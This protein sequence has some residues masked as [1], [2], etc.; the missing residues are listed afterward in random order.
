MR[1]DN[2]NIHV[3]WNSDIDIDDWKDYVSEELM[4]ESDHE[5][6]PKVEDYIENNFVNILERIN[7]LNNDYLD[8]ERANLDIETS[9]EIICIADLGLWNGR[10]SGYNVE[11]NNI[12]EIFHSHIRGMSD[13][14][15]YVELND[16]VLELKCEESHHD[17][18]NYYTYRE[19]KPE[20][21]DEIDVLKDL[22]YEGKATQ[23][24][25]D[26]YTRPLGDKVQEVYGFEL[27][28][29][30]ADKAIEK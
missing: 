13:L 8:D 20:L 27:K 29:K 5:E 15:F 22:I 10:A 1:K 16:G 17:G 14:C 19:V 4:N 28:S 6:Y 26:Y 7:D 2:E 12:N 21:S 30:E 18:T 23:K 3:I 9:G 25:I 24:D 11:G